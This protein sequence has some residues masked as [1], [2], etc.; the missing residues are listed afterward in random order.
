MYA[1]I[2]NDKYW[3]ETIYA[4]SYMP[5]P[6]CSAAAHSSSESH[7]FEGFKKTVV[8]SIRN[9][10]RTSYLASEASGEDEVA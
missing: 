1:N 3:T 5:L 9:F 8:R 10:Q 6:E 7:R 4:E 2:F